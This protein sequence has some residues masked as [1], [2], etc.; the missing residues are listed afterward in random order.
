MIV[1]H[2]PIIVHD[3]Y[4]EADLVNVLRRNIKHYSFIVYW[5]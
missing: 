1:K 4:E 5:I 2:L 3:S